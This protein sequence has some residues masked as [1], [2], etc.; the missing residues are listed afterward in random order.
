[1]NPGP[2][3]ALT[4]DF[5]TASGYVAQVKAVLLSASPSTRIVD[6]S[7]EVSPHSVREAELLL[8]GVAFAFPV[9]TVHV[10]VV[11]PG[12]G[13]SRRGIAVRARGLTFVGPDNGVL[14]VALATPGAE[15]VALDRPHLFRAPVAP[16]FHARDVFA[17][18]AAELAGGLALEDAGTPIADALPSTLPVPRVSRSRVEGEVLGSDRFGNLLTNVPGRLAGKRV[19][20]AGRAAQLVRTYGEGPREAL[21]ALVGSDGYVELAVR[22]G[23]AASLLAA[24]AGVPVICELE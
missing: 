20:V 3:I 10:V 19:L 6:V 23:S 21:L 1:M 5:G 22:E 2:I 14:G 11:D 7:H 18:V 17:P 12:V 9:G 4:T 16:T 13:T 8:R 15:C 24:A